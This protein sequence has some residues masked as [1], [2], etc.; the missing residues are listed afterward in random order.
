MEVEEEEEEAVE[1]PWAVDEVALAVGEPELE[2][3]S[4]ALPAME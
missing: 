4:A 3:T 2:E 1:A